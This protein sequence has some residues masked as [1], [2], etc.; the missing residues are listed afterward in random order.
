MQGDHERPRPA[1]VITFGHVQIESATSVDL[2]RAKQANTRSGPRTRFEGFELITTKRFCE[3]RRDGRQDIAQWIQLCLSPG[4]LVHRME[5]ARG[6]LVG[7]PGID[8][9]RKRLHRKLGSLAQTCSELFEGG[10][11]LDLIEFRE[12]GVERVPSGNETCA[13]MREIRRMESTKDLLECVETSKQNGTELSHDKAKG[14]LVLI[15]EF[16]LGR[17]LERFVGSTIGFAHGATVCSRRLEC[18]QLIQLI[19]GRRYTMA[20][21]GGR[22]IPKLHRDLGVRI[23]FMSVVLFLAFTANSHAQ[24]IPET[25]DEKAFYSIGAS[26][27]AQLERANPISESELDILVQGVRD[28]VRGKTL[29]VEQKEGA[30]LVRAMLQQRQ[31]RAAEVEGAAAADFL[32]AEARKKGAQKTESGL[33]YTVI[34][35]GSGDSPTATDKVRVHYHGTLRDGSVFDSSVERDKPAEFPLN[36]VIACWTEGVAMMKEGGK[37][38]LICPA[39]IAYGDRSTGRIPAGAALSFEVELLEIVK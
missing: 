12:R 11:R 14:P 22:M 24:G 19:H 32:A 9:P 35:A 1:P 21:T 27:A 38:L 5:N 7:R 6:T 30:T 18:E 25:D 33:I 34:K 15:V 8:D 39:E 31:E 16:V 4:M 36:R 10:W 20:V 28:A 26:M 29:A 37:A 3:E 17:R 2:A 23:A 13:K